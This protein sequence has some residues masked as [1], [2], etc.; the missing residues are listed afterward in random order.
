MKNRALFSLVL[1]ASVIP[2]CSMLPEGFPPPGSGGGSAD[3][4]NGAACAISITVNSCT[5]AGVVL[6]A[7]DLH[8]KTKNEII[9][10]TIS[11]SAY[12]FDARDGIKFKVAHGEF[13]S[14]TAH[15]NRFTWRD[16]NDAGGPPGRRYPYSI[17]ILKSDGSPCVTVDPT[18]INDA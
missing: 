11:G 2:A 15:G 16:K 5:A 12:N 6:S 10:W 9:T 4:G 13:D 1:A 14:P 8:V 17:K 18:I 7:D 3:C